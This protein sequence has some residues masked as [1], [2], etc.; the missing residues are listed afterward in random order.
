MLAK[1]Q[2]VAS[3]SMLGRLARPR[4]GGLIALATVI[5]VMPLFLPNK[6]YYEVAILAGFNV[7]VCVGLNLL[8]GYAG[9]ISLGHAGFFGLGA[10]TSAVLSA[11]FGWHPLAGMA[12]ATAFVGLLAYMIARP[13][14]KLKGHNLAMA[15]LGLGI[16][17]TIVLDN[18]RELTGG[19]TGLDVPGIVL[20]GWQLSSEKVWYWLV[21]ALVLLAVWAALNLIESPVGRALRAV[22]GS[23]IAAEAMGVHT[24]RYKVQ[25]FV[26]SAI[27]A[28]L[29]GALTA[30]YT[31][32]I[33]PQQA[34]FVRS[35]EFVT[36][37][38][39]GGMA[40]TF[41]AV[42]GAGILTAL[43]QLL[44]KFHDYEMIVHGILLMGV[45]I[46]MPKGLVPSLTEF[47]RRKLP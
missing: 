34:G 41:G 5:A 47:V 7:I 40:S 23:E 4:T 31:G 17:V 13:T 20:F 15:T 10:Y 2:Q 44:A 21:G 16:I 22:H 38:V 42:V 8:L 14:L 1:S 46:F 18:E 37:I 39:L 9:Q 27:F 26:L 45:L 12:V 3:R 29:A 11:R 28:A 33:T 36:M 25:I 30:H 24:V 43:P 6:F 19:A 32:F 35:I